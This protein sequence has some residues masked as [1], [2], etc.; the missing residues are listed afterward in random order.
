MHP[1]EYDLDFQFVTTD[2]SFTVKNWIDSLISS[3]SVVKGNDDYLLLPHAG[4]SIL[5]T[6]Q[7]YNFNSKICVI[8]FVMQFFV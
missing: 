5:P 6:I 8:C 2:E 4:T 7:N 3:G 1:W